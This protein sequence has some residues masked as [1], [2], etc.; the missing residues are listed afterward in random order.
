MNRLERLLSEQDYVVLDG[1]MGTQLFGAGLEQGMAPEI[2]NTAFPGRVRAIH[3]RYIEAGSQLVL[4]NT[5]GGTSYRLKLHDLQDRVVEL[6]RAAA[7]L[8][9]DEADN[10]PRPVV[11]AGSIGPSGELLVPM[12]TMS[13]DDAK[14]A[15][16]E[17]ARGLAEGGADMLWIETMSDLNEVTA[18][19]EG[20]RSVCDL[21]IAATLSFDTNTRTMMGVTPVKAVLELS[22]WDLIA[23]GANCGA[24]LPD[25]EAAVAAMHA[26]DPS[27]TLIAKANAGIPRWEDSALAYDGTP[28]VMA[29]YARRVHQAGARL[30]GACCGSTPAHIQMMCRALADPTMMTA[31]IP[32][33]QLVAAEK[34]KPGRVRQRRHK[35][36]T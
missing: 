6:N 7:Q 29:G 10:A 25:T 36:R 8:A 15:F 13:Y 12:G 17:Q 28:A 18:A 26:A 9:R 21:P 2:W 24:N 23:I 30:V 14:A 3:R 4:T 32:G 19:I 22:K 11:V 1:A 33:L 35:R 34:K 5:F 27:V 20:V 31:P 16:A